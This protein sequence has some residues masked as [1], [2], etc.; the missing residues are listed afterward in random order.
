MTPDSFRELALSFENV[1]ETPNGNKNSFKVDDKIFITIDNTNMKAVFRLSPKEQNKFSDLDPSAIYPAQAGWG[2]QGWTI[3]ELNFIE[4][5]TL[6]TAITLS[7]CTVAPE[8]LAK[9][10]K[11]KGAKK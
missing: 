5:E 9:K 1:V 11:K 4:P 8:D 3:F 7:Y 10:Y 6:E 2:K